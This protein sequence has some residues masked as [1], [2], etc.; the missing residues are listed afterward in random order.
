M[1]QVLRFYT[2][3]GDVKQLLEDTKSKIDDIAATWSADEKQS[4]LEETMACFRFGGSLMVYL[5][6][7][8]AGKDDAASH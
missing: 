8:S 3:E 6:P 2:W 1:P 4:C 5:K 7:P